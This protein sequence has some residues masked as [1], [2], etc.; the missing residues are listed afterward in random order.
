MGKLSAQLGSGSLLVKPRADGCSAGMVRLASAH[1]FETYFELVGRG[2]T[3][4]KEGTFRFQTGVIE[5]NSNR[6]DGYLIEP[7]IGTDHLEIAGAELRRL[8]VGGWLE[9]TVG[10]IEQDG[11]TMR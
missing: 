1:E 8:V 7:F 11:L 6:D 5:M 2:V 3:E 4:A 10:V 9:L